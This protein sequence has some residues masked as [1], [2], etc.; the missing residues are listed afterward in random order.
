M[1]K[2]TATLTEDQARKDADYPVEV[3]VYSDGASVTPSSATVTV[4]DPDGTDQIDAES[5]SIASNVLTYTLDSAETD[6]LWENAFLKIDV[7]ISSVVYRFTFIFD[8]VLNVLYPVISDTDLQGH[9]PKIDDDKFTDET[10]YTRQIE[11]AWIEVKRDI[12]NKGRRPHMLIDG[13]QLR[14]VHLT[15]TLEIICDSFAKDEEDIWWTRKLE[16][17]ERYSRLMSEMII[18]YDADEDGIITEDENLV[19]LGQIVMRT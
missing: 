5:M 2:F 18:K 1:A 3:T 12:K 16:F 15:R 10:S 9:Y 13:S 14:E 6:T 7:T 17:K 4:T 19:S 8:V 11:E